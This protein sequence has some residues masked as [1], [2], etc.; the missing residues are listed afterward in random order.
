MPKTGAETCFVD[1]NVLLTATDRSRSGHA[2]A[3][4]LLTKARRC[5]FPLGVSGQIVREYL[6]VATRQLENNGLG[7]AQQAAVANVTQMLQRLTF[8]EESEAVS[9]RLRELVG[10]RQV[11]GRRIHDAN[12][13]ATMLTH[14]VRIL[15]TDNAPDF[16]AFSEVEAHTLADMVRLISATGST[17][18][19]TGMNEPGMSG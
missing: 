13:A 4:L 14:G 15:V 5:G 1:T 18:A 2:E 6:V 10:Q 3:K 19:S 12:V 11:A 7:L 8:F 17:P 9:V 16:A